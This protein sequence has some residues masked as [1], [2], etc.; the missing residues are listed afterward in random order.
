[1]GKSNLLLCQRSEPVEDEPKEEKEAR[2]LFIAAN[3]VPWFPVIKQR[4]SQ[5][6]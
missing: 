4:K 6:E 1:M 2:E 5:V 3:V